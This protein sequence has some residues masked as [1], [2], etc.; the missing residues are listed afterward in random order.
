MVASL[1]QPLHAPSRAHR[2]DLNTLATESVSF[3]ENHVSIVDTQ[4]L[5]THVCAALR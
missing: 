2:I 3:G 1:L 5:A 4:T